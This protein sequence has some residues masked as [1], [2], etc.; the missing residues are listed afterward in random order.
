MVELRASEEKPAKSHLFRV[1]E[2][3]CTPRHYWA[4]VSGSKWIIRARH[5][6]Q[7]AYIH[8]HHKGSAINL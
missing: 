8:L 5:F 2:V 6:S 1:M 7:Q 4:V 3:V